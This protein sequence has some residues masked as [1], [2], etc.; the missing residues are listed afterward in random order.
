M[1]STLEH[2]MRILGYLIVAIGSALVALPVLYFVFVMV[3]IRSME[4]MKRWE[5][6]NGAG[7]LLGAMPLIGLSMI[8]YSAS[9]LDFQLGDLLPNAIRIG[10][11]ILALSIISAV[12]RLTYRFGFN[13]SGKSDETKP[14]RSA[15]RTG[16]GPS[17]SV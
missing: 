9:L 10:I 16:Y 8:N 14:R 3:R 13:R 15:H 5:T 17:D 6:I 7:L 11:P 2:K 12:I 1:A 4:R